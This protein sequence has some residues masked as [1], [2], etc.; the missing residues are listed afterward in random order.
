MAAAVARDIGKP[1]HEAHLSETG[2]LL[3]DIIFMAKHLKEWAKDESAPYVPWM[4]KAVNPKIR[5]EPLGAVL[6]I[7]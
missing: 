6:I 5:K 7:G 1:A 2:W 3:N 4:H